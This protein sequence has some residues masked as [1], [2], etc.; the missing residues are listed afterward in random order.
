[1]EHNIRF[2]W[3]END[4][5]IYAY[6]KG[7]ALSF[8]KETRKYISLTGHYDTGEFR[9]VTNPHRIVKP[10]DYKDMLAQ[11]PEQIFISFFRNGL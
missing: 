11:V 5:N 6:R 2:I 3:F 1:M 10:K 7:W 8:D 9:H 4:K